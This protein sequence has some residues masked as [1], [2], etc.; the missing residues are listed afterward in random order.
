MGPDAALVGGGHAQSR[1]RQPHA[2]ERR[3]ARSGAGVDRSSDC[4]RCR[5]QCAR[6]RVPAATTLHD[7]ARL[8]RVGRFHRPDAIRSGGALGGCPADEAAPLEGRRP[9]HRDL[10]RHDR[11]DGC[12]RRELG[13]RPDLQ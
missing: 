13:D 4:Q 11:A 1:S 7:A 8:T 12:G 10:Q 5:C 3:R 9:E 2:G 6:E